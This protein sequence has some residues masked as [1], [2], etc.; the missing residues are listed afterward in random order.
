MKSLLVAIIALVLG[1]LIGVFTY[2][3]FVPPPFDVMARAAAFEGDNDYFF[4]NASE[5]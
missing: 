5:I 3:R 2:T 4:Q 1:A